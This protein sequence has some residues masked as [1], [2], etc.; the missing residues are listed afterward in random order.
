MP[1]VRPK[2]ILIDGHALAYQQFFALPVEKFTTAA[3]EPTN[4][5]FGF[6]RTLLDI[7]ETRPDYLAVSFDQGL[8]GRDVV[9]EAYKGTRDKMNSDLFIQMDRIRELVGAFN[10]PILEMEGTEA[11]DVIGTIARQAEAQGVEVQILTGD[12]DLL[13]LITDHI[14]VQ[15]PA[16]KK[17][18]QGLQFYDAERV[19]AE[20]GVRPDQFADYKG[21]VGD[22]SDNIP[23]VK[24]VGDKSAAILLQQY[25]TLREV[26]EHVHDQKPGLQ[27]YLSAGKE[28][29]FLSQMLATIKT[30]LPL[31]L[32]LP[33][34]IAHDYQRAGVAELFRK[35]EFRRLIDRLP[36]DQTVDERDPDDLILDSSTPRLSDEDADLYEMYAPVSKSSTSQLPMFGSGVAA[37]PIKSVVTTIVVDTPESLAALVEALAAAEQI[38]FDTETTAL[39]TITAHLVGISLAVNETEGYY[40]PVGHVTPDTRQLPLQTVMDAI[41]PALTDPR[42]PKIGHNAAFDLVIM[43]RHG[44]DVAPIGF[45]PMI[46]EAVVNPESRNKGLKSLAFN[47]LGVEM[48]PIDELIGKGKSQITMDQVEIERAAPYAAADAVMT[49]RLAP[50]LRADLEQKK[51]WMLYRELE[52]P[53]IPVLASMQMTGVRL[54]LPYLRELSVEFEKRLDEIRT[55]IYTQAGQTF[56]IGSPK[57]LNDI[58]FDKLKLPTTGLSK[59]THGFTVDAETLE[60]LRDKHPIA[61]RLMDWRSLEKLKSTYVDS[62]QKLVDANERVHTTYNQTGAVTGRLSSD[63]PNLQNIPIR[64]EE[65]RRVR[66]AFIAREGCQLLSVDYSQIELRILA[67]YSGD[68]FM[69]E[70]FE[71]DQDIHTATAAAIFNIPYDQVQKE[72]RYMAKR[73]NFGLLYGMG[74]FRLSKEIGLS[75]AGATEFIKTYFARLPKIEQYLEGSKQLAAKQGYLETMF[76]RRRDFSV[77][78]NADRDRTSSIARARAERE[79]INMPIQGTN[80]DIIKKAMIEL[81]ERLEANGFQAALILQVHDELV[82]EV[83]TGEVR[84]VAAVVQTVMGEAAKLVVPLATEAKVGL[85]WADMTL[86]EEWTG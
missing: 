47:R 24:G 67:H 54:D 4:A 39:D 7:L 30:D 43:R 8:S 53:L 29:A 17:D 2:L 49:F 21:L 75:V 14:F 65:G 66:R 81:P 38:A 57:Q 44:I 69:I 68:Q 34:C 28:S 76:G 78:Q 19:V 73:I 61:A 74:A 13:Q 31:T 82:L 64:T 32:D 22:S 86:V 25:G 84:A 45:D 36:P 85:N 51:L 35:L 60:N 23:G 6:A 20:F 18:Q 15:L 37:P 11:D 33:R 72:Q 10:I 27:K 55:D 40:I 63:T 79:A 71:R 70:A 26:Y 46:A 9:Y 3:G 48:T 41:R 52:V 56:N 77:L 1:D 80:A 58:L 83:P 62:L 59:T 42:K 12:R 16:R 50:I 5:T